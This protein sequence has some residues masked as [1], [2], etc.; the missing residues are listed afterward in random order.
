L[1]NIFSKNI[2]GMNKMLTRMWRKR[3]TPPLRVGLQTGTITLEK[4]MVVSQKLKIDLPED[5]AALLGIYPKDAP[6]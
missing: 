5:P 3:N 6:P 1:V 4:N 2:N